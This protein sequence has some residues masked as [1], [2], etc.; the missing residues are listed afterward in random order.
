MFFIMNQ[1]VTLPFDSLLYHL[2][3]LATFEQ[4]N[5]VWKGA[6]GQKILGSLLSV[7]AS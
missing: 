1:K 7:T 5:V 3:G 2:F 4:D 6:I